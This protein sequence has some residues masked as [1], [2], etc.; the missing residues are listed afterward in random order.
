MVE[1]LR[2]RWAEGATGQVIADELGRGLS[3]SAVLGKASKL[4]LSKEGQRR[5]GGTAMSREEAEASLAR[6]VEQH[7]EQHVRKAYAALG[8]DVTLSRFVKVKRDVVFERQPRQLSL[9]N[10]R[11]RAFELGR[12]IFH[13]RGVKDVDSLPAVLV[14]GHANV[15]I[16]RDVRK[17]RLFRGYWIFA[18][19]LEERATCPTSCF[20][21][22]TCYGNNMPYARRVDHRDEDRLKAAIHRDVVKELGRRGRVGILVR[23]HALG[24]FFSVSYVEFWLDLLRLHPNLAVYGYTARRPWD[25]IGLAVQRGKEEF[26]RRFAIRWS[27]GQCDLDA[28]VPL[29]HPDDCPPNAFVC[30]EQTGRSAACA[31]CGL[32]WNSTKNVAFVEH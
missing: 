11:H 18:L 32:C 30:P 21:W 20:H 22:T 5:P 8:D 10:L 19:T 15:K 9:G 25:P 26:D 16:G 2:L 12:S 3:R 6:Y 14:S 24:D 27:D 17:G 7:G 31:T 4:G 28:T 23:L 13:R 29:A 1:Q